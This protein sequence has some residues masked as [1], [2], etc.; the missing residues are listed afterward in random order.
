MRASGPRELASRGLRDYEIKGYIGRGSYGTVELA[1]DRHSGEQVV[2]KQIGRT[3]VW[4]PLHGVLT[5]R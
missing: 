3:A 1:L 4:A 2:I 5:V